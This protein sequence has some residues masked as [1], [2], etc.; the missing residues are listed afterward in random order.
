[1]DIT[2]TRIFPLDSNYKSVY[3][4]FSS[5]IQDM[6]FKAVIKKIFQWSDVSISDQFLAKFNSQT[7]SI[8]DVINAYKVKK[9]V[10]SFK[11]HRLNDYSTSD[12]L[13]IIEP[14]ETILAIK[15]NK[16]QIG[17]LPQ[18]FIEKFLEDDQIILK[19]NCYQSNPFYILT[20]V[21]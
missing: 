2:E 19:V 1:M 9:T 4:Y 5:E 13:I 18:G 7:N 17:L 12:L 8:Q 3:K 16:F 11:L 20:K 21:G 6:L 14:I 10:K 15:A